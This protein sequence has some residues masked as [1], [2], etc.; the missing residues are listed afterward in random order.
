MFHIGMNRTHSRDRLLEQSNAKFIKNAKSV[1]IRDKQQC[2]QCGFQS[3]K[4]QQVVTK[5]EM[6]T[7]A[8]FVESNLMTVCPL[9]FHGLRLGYAAEEKSL[10]FIYLPEL[11]QAELNNIMRLIYFYLEQPEIDVDD[12]DLTQQQQSMYD[13]QSYSR[14]ILMELRD[15]TKMIHDVYHYSNINKIDMVVMMLAKQTEEAYSKRE[16]FF[17]PIRYLV[18]PSLMAELNKHYSETVFSKL[19]GHQEILLSANHK[20]HT[21]IEENN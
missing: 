11:T 15:R 2:S 13:C 1:L 5:N 16:K 14:S 12:N 3:S 8:D 7:D 4:M 18:S 17:A 21:I 10:T 6:Y 19:D 20:L 9:C